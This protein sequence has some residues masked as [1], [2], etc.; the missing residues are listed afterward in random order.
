M[1]AL[2]NS[3]KAADKVLKLVGTRSAVLYAICK[4]LCT[5]QFTARKHDMGKTVTR[6]SKKK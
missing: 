5:E 1:F 3:T 6:R 4:V 2:R